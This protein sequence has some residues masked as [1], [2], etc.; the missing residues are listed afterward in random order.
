MLIGIGLAPHGVG[1]T[2]AGTTRPAR[3]RL[4]EASKLAPKMMAPLIYLGQSYIR[5]RDWPQQ[6]HISNALTLDPK[7]LVR[8]G[9]M[10]QIK[11]GTQDWEGA[12]LHYS[13]AAKTIDRGVVWGELGQIQGQREKWKEAEEAFSKAIQLNPKLADLYASYG[14]TAK[15]GKTDAA[16]T[17]YQQAYK[18]TLPTQAIWRRLAPRL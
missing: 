1:V 10:G 2:I 13:K 11:I 3:P 8:K 9:A 4:E 12:A 16:I 15:N 7:Q 14:Y 18:E 17:V 5:E 6:K